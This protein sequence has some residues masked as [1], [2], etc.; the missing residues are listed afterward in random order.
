M[1]EL[2]AP[3]NQYRVVGVD[4][5]EGADYLV[6]DYDSQ[7]E[8]FDYADAYNKTRLSSIDNVYY[9]YND[10]GHYLRGN[11]TVGGKVNH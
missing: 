5:F 4:L 3:K 6:G 7:Q 10:R 8:A 11:E 2:K 9:V 1:T